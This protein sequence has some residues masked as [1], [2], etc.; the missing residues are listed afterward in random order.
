M[1]EQCTE[2]G[3]EI[4]SFVEVRDDAEIDELL[5]DDATPAAAV[6]VVSAPMFAKPA[7]PGRGKARITKKK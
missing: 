6:P 2:A 3:F 5:R 1:I 7:R 4:D